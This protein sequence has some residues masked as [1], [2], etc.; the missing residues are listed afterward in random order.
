MPCST[1]ACVN[2]ATYMFKL[3]RQYVTSLWHK[4]SVTLEP[5]IKPNTLQPHLHS[6]Y[7]TPPQLLKWGFCHHDC[8]NIWQI[9]C[10]TVTK[11]DRTIIVTCTQSFMT[12]TLFHY[13]HYALETTSCIPFY[14]VKT[15]SANCRQESL[16]LGH[17]CHGSHTAHNMKWSIHG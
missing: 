1:A 4:H 5:H 16:S 6:H 11:H 3:P 14:R 12:V 13:I 9:M 10:I 8:R 17:S 7:L 15:P 2:T